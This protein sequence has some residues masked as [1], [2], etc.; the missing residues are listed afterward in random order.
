MQGAARVAP[1]PVRDRQAPQTRTRADSPTSA[2]PERFLPQR[3]PAL[4]RQ[5]VP[6]SKFRSPESRSSPLSRHRS[7]DRRHSHTATHTHRFSTPHRTAP[8]ARGIAG[9]APHE[10]HHH[11]F[12]P[13]HAISSLPTQTPAASSRASKPRSPR[14]R[15][16]RRQPSPPPRRRP[17]SSHRLSTKTLCNPSN[18]IS[19][20][21]V[22]DGDRGSLCGVCSQIQ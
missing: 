17:L 20:T 11:R 21:I 1:R 6:A 9:R 22:I 14:A 2:A 5:P 10:R 19:I 3:L 13:P 4:S 7:I 16:A 15:P 8:T 18:I 12:A